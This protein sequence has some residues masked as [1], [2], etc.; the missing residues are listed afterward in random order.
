MGTRTRVILL[1]QFIHFCKQ[2]GASLEQI[3]DALM[4]AGLDAKQLEPIFE[5][6]VFGA[7]IDTELSL[8]IAAAKTAQGELERS[9]VGFRP[10][11]PIQKKEIS[12]TPA[13][14]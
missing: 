10:H 14:N 13:S 7:K 4:V 6:H 5:K 12:A 1:S 3:R 9:L 2:N 11:V 8:D